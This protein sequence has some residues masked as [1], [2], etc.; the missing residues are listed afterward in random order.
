VKSVPNY[1]DTNTFTGNAADNRDIASINM[2]TFI[3][4]KANSTAIPCGRWGIVGDNSW[5][6]AG[7]TTSDNKVQALTSTGWQAGSDSCANSNGNAVYWWLTKTP[8]YRRS[9]APLF[10]Q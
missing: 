4:A 7:D 8:V 2:P 6:F 3:W 10:F 9:V 5:E 1:N